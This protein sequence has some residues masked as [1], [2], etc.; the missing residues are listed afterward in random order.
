MRIVAQKA[1]CVCAVLWH[2]GT[3]APLATPWAGVITISAVE[4]CVI[5]R[6]EGSLDVG[7]KERSQ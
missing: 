2:C 5:W 4:G 1:W 7:E 6:V 3:V